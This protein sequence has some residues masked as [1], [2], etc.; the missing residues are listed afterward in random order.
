[1]MSTVENIAQGGIR[2]F[3]GGVQSRS[4]MQNKTHA[5]FNLQ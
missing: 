1:M 5:P 3:S 4:E 2:I